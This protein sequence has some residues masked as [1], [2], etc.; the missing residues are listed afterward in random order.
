MDI[1]MMLN[2][3]IYEHG[4][5]FHLFVSSLIS[6]FSV[7]QFFGYR[8]FTSLVRFIRYFIFLVAIANEIFFLR[9]VFDV[10]LLMYKNIFDINCWI[11]TLQPAVLPNSLIKLSSFGGRVYRVFYVFYHVICK[12][13]Q[14]Y[15]F[16]SSLD[17]FYFFCLFDHCGQNFQYYIE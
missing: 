1:L 9:S 12:Q 17:V 8:S 11:L 6:V 16:L 4:T 3:P 2:L 5:C 10:S 14:I 15:F 7:V 13:G